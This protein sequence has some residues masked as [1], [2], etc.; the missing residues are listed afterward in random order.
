MLQTEDDLLHGQM[1]LADHTGSEEQNEASYQPQDQM[2]IVGVFAA[3]LT[4]LGSQQMLQGPKDKLNPT[5]PP[6]PADQLRSAPLSL[7]TQQI[8]TVLPRLIHN[9]HGHLAIGGT[10]GL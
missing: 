8:E 1:P 7:Q 6:P 3:H 5:A 4:G 2:P 10:G 9:D